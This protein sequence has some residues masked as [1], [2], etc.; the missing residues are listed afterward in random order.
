MGGATALGAGIVLLDILLFRPLCPRS[1]SGSA[2]FEV[3]GDALGLFSMAR[4][5]SWGKFF[6]SPALYELAGGI[7]A[8]FVGKPPALVGFMGGVLWLSERP[9]VVQI[10]IVALIAA[11]VGW[12]FRNRWKNPAR[13]VS[14]VAVPVLLVVSLLADQPTLLVR[15]ATSAVALLAI[16]VVAMLGRRLVDERVGVMAAFLVAVA[17]AVWV[18]ASM[19]NV[20][21]LYVAALP[22]VLL[23]T[24]RVIDSPTMARYSQ[25]GGAL[26]I[27]SFTRLEGAAIVLVVLAGLVITNP[28]SAALGRRLGLPVMALMIVVVPLGGWSAMNALR[29]GRNAG[30]SPGGGSVLWSGACDEVVYG[31][32]R[33]FWTLCSPETTVEAPVLL[34]QAVDDLIGISGYA[35][36]VLDRNNEVLQ[37]AMDRPPRS[38]ATP[39]ASAEWV[40]AEYDQVMGTLPDGSRGVGI[41]VDDRPAGDPELVLQPGQHLR[42]GPNALSGFSEA[43]LDAG[44]GV[45]AMRYYAERPKDLPGLGAARVGRALG[46]YRPVQTVRLDS[47]V[48]GRGP[49]QPW[50]A[51][52]FWWASVPLAVLGWL[53]LRG[54]RVLWPLGAVVGVVIVVVAVSL[55]IPR[56]RLGLDVVACVLAAVPLVAWIGGRWPGVWSA[57]PGD[58]R[59]DN[60]AKPTADS[61]MT[62]TSKVERT[63]QSPSTTAAD[64][65]ANTI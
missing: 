45:R 34:P 5:L 59:S 61:T 4:L 22:L 6:I 2:C 58:D 38:S 15:V 37:R 7:E 48:E 36:R 49:W 55:G 33:G 28:G 24:L 30:V 9:L 47:L 12:A 50:G 46:V 31:E 25:L 40:R 57:P 27:L 14:E 18:N 8:P 52:A 13:R 43:E 21:T 65:Q 53:R 3:V 29:Q 19:L 17:P 54:R 20:E 64:T 60:D 35:D 11:G 44:A 23:T 63:R 41:W 16:P 1:E 39:M 32:L 51:M 56:Y 26:M 62:A 10:L 42:V